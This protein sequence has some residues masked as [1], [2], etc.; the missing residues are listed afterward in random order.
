VSIP[1]TPCAADLPATPAKAWTVPGYARYLGVSP[2]KVYGWVRSGE[3]VAFNVGT[4]LSGK[5]QW[6]ISPEAAAAFERR[7]RGGPPPATA[8]RKR[9]LTGEIDFFPDD[10][11]DEPTPKRR[12]RAQ[13]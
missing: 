12:G 10:A 7:R 8:P 9:R 5:P 13:A 11:D 2:D 6:R 1:P 3:L 4:V